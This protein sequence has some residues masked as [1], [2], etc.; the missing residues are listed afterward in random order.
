M[1]KLRGVATNRVLLPVHRFPFWC[2]GFA[3]WTKRATNASLDEKRQRQQY[4]E[5][6]HGTMRVPLVRRKTNYNSTLTAQVPADSE[7][8][9]GNRSVTSEK[10]KYEIDEI[11][12]L[13]WKQLEIVLT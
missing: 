8:E 9:T 4:A 1:P 12:I 11:W 13:H 2:V 3:R 7:L 10:R 5:E 6:T